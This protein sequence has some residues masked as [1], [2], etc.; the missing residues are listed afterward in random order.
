MKPNLFLLAL[1]AVPAAA[2]AQSPVSATGA[3]IRETAPGQTAAAGYVTL[4]N[5]GA[6]DRLLGG[7]SDLG[8][9][10]IHSM[11]MDGGIMRMRALPQGLPLPTGKPV[12]LKS[13]G[14]HL[15]LT[16]LSGRLRAGQRVP[17]ELQF[18]RAGKQRVVFE[19]RPATAAADAHAHH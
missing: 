9:V 6:P 5:G 2:Q 13:G 14:T 10:Q 18:A 16:N 19:V 8:K 17:V 11:T 7:R 12:A 1:L 15:M 3:W 4:L